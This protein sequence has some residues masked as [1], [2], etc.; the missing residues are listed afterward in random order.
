[1]PIQK[2][3]ETSIEG[4]H[5]AIKVKKELQAS[6]EDEEENGWTSFDVHGSVEKTLERRFGCK[7]PADE[8]LGIIRRRKVFLMDV[9]SFKDNTDFETLLGYMNTKVNEQKKGESGH[10]R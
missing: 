2:C 9:D 4:L 10:V 6:E 7:T 5:T 8:K 1:M 3:Q